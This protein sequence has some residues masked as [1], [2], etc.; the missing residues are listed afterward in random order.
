MSSPPWTPKP[1]YRLAEETITRADVDALISWLNNTP[2]PNPGAVPWLTQGKLVREFEAAFAKEVGAKHAIFVNSGSSANL[3]AWSLP[4]AYDFFVP[5]AERVYLPN[6]RPDQ[7]LEKSRRV[8]VP[9]VAWA[10][11]VMP[12]IQI[13]YK[14]IPCEADEETWGLDPKDLRRL[15]E[16]EEGPP[17][18]VLLVHVL[19]VPCKMKE[20]RALRDEFGFLLIEDACGAFGS[21]P[22]GTRDEKA[23]LLSTYSTYFAHQLST[24]EGGFV[25]THGDDAANILRMLRAHGWAADG[26]PDWQKRLATS[27]DVDPFREKFTFYV[28]GFNV[29][30]TDLAAH[31]GLSQMKRAGAVAEARRANHALYAK[32]FA[33]A[34]HFT[35]QKPGAETKVAS[36]AFGVLASSRAHRTKVGE[37]LKAKGIETRPLLGGNTTKQPYWQRLYGASK[38]TRPIADRIH[39]CGFQ[40]PNHPGLSASDIDYICETVLA[41]KP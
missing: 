39:D 2:G 21:S 25:C 3:L 4:F 27:V 17:A 7:D 31:L 40:L 11:S 35:V 18:I 5:V 10:T 6:G 12:A 19:G 36:I 23:E 14:P 20:I 28:P 29:R 15:C 24:V 8:V 34:A 1:E 41:V 38:R 22:V 26:D 9:A 16:K 33:A 32:H 13:G 37:A 30:G